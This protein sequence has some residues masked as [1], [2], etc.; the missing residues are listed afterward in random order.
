MLPTSAPS[1]VP[2]PG[3]VAESVVRWLDMLGLDAAGI[4][5]RLVLTATCGLA[6]ASDQWARRAL[7]LLRA[8]AAELTG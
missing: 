7:G 8:G 4:G 6:G 3:Q 2:T 1:T 5:P